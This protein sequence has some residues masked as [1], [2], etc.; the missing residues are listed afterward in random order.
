MEIRKYLGEMPQIGNYLNTQSEANFFSLE[1]DG[2][3]KALLPSFIKKEAVVVLKSTEKLNNG[4][5]GFIIQ[6][7]DLDEDDVNIPVYISEKKITLKQFSW[8]I[9]CVVTDF[10]RKELIIWLI[11]ESFS[12]YGGIVHGNYK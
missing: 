5:E 12:S 11:Q 10:L 6:L 4:N 3:W 1:L 9:D 8:G 7:N 2:E